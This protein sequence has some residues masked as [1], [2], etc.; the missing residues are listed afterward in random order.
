[1]D[2]ILLIDDDE[3]LIHFLSRFF[4]RK[5][6]AVTA[7]ATGNLALERIAAETFDLILLDYKMPGL[8]GL[9][10]LKRI[11]AQQV[12]TPVIFMTAYGST[13]TAIEAM[14]RGA[15]DY[16]VKP[17]ERQELSRIVSEA[18]QLNARMKQ[19]VRLP[20][21]PA[22]DAAATGLRIVGQSKP[23]Q[24]VYKRIGQVAETDVAVLIGGESGTGKE[25]VARAIY[26]HSRR[27]DRTFLAINCA[28]IPENLIESELFGYERGAFSGAERT[29]IGKLER[30]DGGTCFLDEIG[31]MSLAMQAKL[32]R[33]L[34]DGDFERLG[35]RE[36]IRV[37]VR[38]I[39]AT[40]KDL[41]REVQAGRF[42]EDLY[43]RLKVITI[44]LPPL[45]RRS[46]DISALVDYFLARFSAEYAKPVATLAPSAMAR[47]EN[48]DWPGNVRE[49]ENCMRRS[50]LLCAGDIITEEHLALQTTDGAQG[51]AA[52]TA[53]LVEHLR[54]Q[55]EQLI[56]AIL[57][58]SKSGAHANIIEMVEELLILKALEA[59]DNNQVQAARMLGISRNT[60]R[61]RLKRHRE[62]S[63]APDTS[64]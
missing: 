19:V 37:D 27:R 30:C 35:G 12:K 36:T 34:Q 49:L 44:Q 48:H 54:N 2:K 10:T 20:G 55:L 11:K 51:T 8:N 32:L 23:M 4:K 14:K 33:V 46:E 43:Y 61:H 50:I 31:D 6:Y 53:Q 40:N 42:R 16:L 60:L 38:I 9:D 24:E 18:L 47:L 57:R 5:G 39:A 17:F 3:G 25:L 45:R 1:M 26:H 62:K 15:Y 7:C 22:A 52:D 58:L 64:A 63:A 21:T 28:A 29:C 41:A 56:P 59:C 13:D